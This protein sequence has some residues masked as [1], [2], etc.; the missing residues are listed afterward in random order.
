MFWSVLK[1]FR[2]SLGVVW[3]LCLL[4]ENRDNAKDNVWEMNQWR[5][6]GSELFQKQYSWLILTSSC[7]YTLA[8]LFK[9]TLHLF[10][11]KYNMFFQIWMDDQGLF[12]ANWNKWLVKKKKMNRMIFF[13]MKIYDEVQIISIIF[14]E[15]RGLSWK[16]AFD[17]Y[18]R[19]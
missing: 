8:V 10:F 4:F 11:M 16:G 5:W 3:S 19:T 17:Y 2:F 6:T 18:F 13:G 7:L 15:M 12:S 1:Y 14:C 9:C